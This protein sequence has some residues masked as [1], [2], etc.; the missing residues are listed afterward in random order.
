V[1]VDLQ[2]IEKLRRKA[3]LTQGEIAARIGLTAQRW[4]NIVKG[5]AENISVK[6]L[7]RIALALGVESA[8]LLIRH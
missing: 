4:N 5:R 3:G 6:T 8:D 2:K 7:D 1:P